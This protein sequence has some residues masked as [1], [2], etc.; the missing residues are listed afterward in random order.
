MDTDRLKKEFSR[1]YGETGEQASVFFAP[2]R[3]NLIGEHTDYN[4]GWVMPCAIHLGTTLLIRKNDLGLIRF[5]AID[6]EEVADIAVSK[7]Y[8]SAGDH[9]YNYPLGVVDELG[10]KH[11]LLPQGV[12]LF[13]SGDLPVSAGLSSSASVEM[14]TAVALNELFGYANDRLELVKL[15]QRAENRFVGVSCGIMDQYT[16]GFGKKENAVI[17]DCRSLDSEL[18]PVPVEEYQL[19]IVNTN[20]PRKLSSS[21]YNQRVDECNQAVKEMQASYP[22][23]NSLRD[24][25]FEALDKLED[26]VEDTVLRKRARHVISENQRVLQSAQALKDSDLETFGLLMQASHRSLKMDYEVTGRELDI[27]AENANSHPGCIGARMTG[28]GFGGCTVNLVMRDLVMDFE[29]SLE[30]KYSRLTGVKPA[31]YYPEISDG[32]RRLD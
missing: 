27:L 18:I 7:K 26:L 29:F 12:D 1:I 6:F 5:R 32:A 3:V 24:I 22:E 9:W 19:V 16:V 13:F 28:A 25:P 17:L 30:K 10:R 20:V 2:G 8:S 31:F 15:S 4:D 21:L 11:G 14:A 23:A